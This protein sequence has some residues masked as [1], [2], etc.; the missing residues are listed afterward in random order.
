[1][2]LSKDKKT[3]PVKSLLLHLAEINLTKFEIFR[4]MSE[5]AT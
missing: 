4:C 3:L 1:M 2:T 5:M